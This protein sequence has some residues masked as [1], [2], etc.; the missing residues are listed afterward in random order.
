MTVVLY[1]SIISIKFCIR[2][3]WIFV[4]GHTNVPSGNRHPFASIAQPKLKAKS[5]KLKLKYKTNQSQI[6]TQKP[7]LYT[8]SYLCMSFKKMV[9]AEA[10]NEWVNAWNGMAWNGTEHF[11]CA[12]LLFSVWIGMHTAQ[13]SQIEL[14]LPHSA[15]ASIFTLAQFLPPVRTYVTR[16][17]SCVHCCL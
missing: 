11:L 2:C 14:P 15:S 12:R 13:Q 8:Y 7:F 5:V 10:A 4:W 17:N 3:V 6:L 1:I 9:I 16:L